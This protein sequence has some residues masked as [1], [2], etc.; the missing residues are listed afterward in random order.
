MYAISQRIPLVSICIPA[1]RS[2]DFITETLFSALSQSMSD[3]EVI[4]SNDGAIHTPALSQFQHDKRLRIIQQASRLGWV[5][6]TNAVLAEARAPYAMVLPHDD[7]LDPHY[8]SACLQVLE[9][10]KNT[11]SVCTDLIIGNQVVHPIEIRGTLPARVTY[12]MQNLYNSYVYRA[13]FRRRDT[14]RDFLQLRSN[15]PTDFSVDT[16]WILQHAVLGEFRRAPGA[17]YWKRLSQSSTHIRWSQLLPGMLK[18]A[19]QTHCQ[20]M[21]DILEQIE[22]DSTLINT[23]FE[24]RCDPRRVLEAPPYLKKVFPPDS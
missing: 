22:I 10:E 20:Q 8:L 17:F 11:F 4:V 21:L 3:I 23:L 15:P 1:Y 16:L 5:M 12:V 6:N 13:V 9:S 2:E 24:K 14:D 18:S 19:W 7:V